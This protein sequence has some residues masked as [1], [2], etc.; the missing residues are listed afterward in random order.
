MTEEAEQTEAIK[1]WWLIN[2][3]E[4]TPPNKA[5]IAATTLFVRE[6]E[7]Q[8]QASILEVQKLRRANASNT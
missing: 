2:P 5:E 6:A 3:E 4:Q 7:K 1:I 8:V